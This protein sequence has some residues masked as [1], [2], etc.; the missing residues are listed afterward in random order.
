VIL[1]SLFGVS[2]A[3]YSVFIFILQMNL[4]HCDTD[5]LHKLKW[6]SQ[7]LT[8]SSKA[9]QLIAYKKEQRHIRY[10]Y[11]NELTEEQRYLTDSLKQM[12]TRI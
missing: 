3:K 1:L 10:A 7:Q 8:N 6:M 11:E 2:K 9:K 12:V 4:S 5:T